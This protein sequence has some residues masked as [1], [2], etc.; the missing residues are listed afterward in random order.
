MT[1]EQTNDLERLQL[2]RVRLNPRYLPSC[3]VWMSLVDDLLD[4]K[5][6][7]VDGDEDT[8]MEEMKRKDELI[9]KQE[10]EIKRISRINAEI[11]KYA[12]NEVLTPNRREAADD[13]E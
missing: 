7:A 6:R 8:V 3:Q 11:C 9:E 13:V 12:I 5:K 10:K 2:V 1:S 4:E